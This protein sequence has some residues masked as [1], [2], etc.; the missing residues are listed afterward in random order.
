MT[1]WNAV[2]SSLCRN[3]IGE[4]VLLDQALNALEF[5]DVLVRRHAD[6]PAGQRGLDQHADLV[7]VAH[8]I[9]VDRPDAR[10]AVGREDDE[11]LAAEQ[12]QRLADRIGGGAMPLGEVGD[13]QTFVGP[14]AALDD[15]VADEL[16]DGRALR[17]RRQSASIPIGGLALKSLIAQLG[18]SR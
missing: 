8:E 14:E 4:V 16:I 7:D 6:E 9:L 18:P 5:G 15:V 11:A 3:W 2:S 17:S 10:A 12:L 1:V 13:D